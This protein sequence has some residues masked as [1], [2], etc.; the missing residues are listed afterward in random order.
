MELARRVGR[1]ATSIALVGGVHQLAKWSVDRYKPSQRLDDQAIYGVSKRFVREYLASE[2]SLVAALDGI[3]H[4]CSLDPE[5]T[6][7]GLMREL[8]LRIAQMMDTISRLGTCTTDVELMTRRHEIQRAEAKAQRRMSKLFERLG[9]L[10]PDNSELLQQ[11]KIVKAELKRLLWGVDTRVD[12]LKPYVVNT[13]QHRLSKKQE[14]L[15]RMKARAAVAAAELT[16]PLTA[17][18]IKQQLSF[19]EHAAEGVAT[20]KT[21]ANGQP[22]LQAEVT[23]LIQR[24]VFHFQRLEH[25]HKRPQRASDV[26]ILVAKINHTAS[27]VRMLLAPTATE[28]EVS[29]AV[30]RIQE[31]LAT[32]RIGLSV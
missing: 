23:Y 15:A 7:M 22:E 6:S 13:E 18:R 24:L 2:P 12:A 9:K 11:I 21:L 29:L 25:L 28:E 8:V 1:L 3:S 4:T 26:D 16:T 32:Y 10:T 17:L 5:A 14:A 19:C 20:F 27:R 31:S 30:V